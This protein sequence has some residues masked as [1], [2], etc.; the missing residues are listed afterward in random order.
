MAISDE[1]KLEKLTRFMKI[2]MNKFSTI[3]ESIVFHFPTSQRTRDVIAT[4]T[5]RC[6]NV[7]NV[8]TALDGCCNRRPVFTGTILTT[9][10]IIII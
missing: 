6:P 10:I 8:W 1:S 4:S 7:H 5:Q 3:C 9:C 2:L